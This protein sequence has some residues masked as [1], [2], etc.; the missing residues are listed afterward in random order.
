MNESDED[1]F[2][3]H[4]VPKMGLRTVETQTKITVAAAST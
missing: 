1:N 2:M 4:I 3:F